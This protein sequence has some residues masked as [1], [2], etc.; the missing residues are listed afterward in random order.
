MMAFTMESYFT[1]KTLD[2]PRYMKWVAF[3][4]LVVD[5]ESKSLSFPVYAC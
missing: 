1:G 2:D 3:L 4:R 5:G